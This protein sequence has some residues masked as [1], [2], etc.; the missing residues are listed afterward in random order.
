MS[1]II[2]IERIALNWVE[3]GRVPDGLIRQGIRW[4]CR[5]R[6]TEIAAHE[7]ESAAPELRAFLDD[8]AKGPIAPLPEQANAQH[9]EV[10]AAF[11]D[12]VLGPHRKYSCCYWPPGVKDL[13]AAET[14]ALALTCERAG[15]ADGQDI[16]ELGCGWGS[17][18]LWLGEH[19]P[20]ARIT[21][22]SN[23][24]SQRQHIEAIATQRGL[25][26][27]RV[28]TADMN[29][30]TTESRFH[31]VVSVEMF[32][33]MR[34][35][36]T[37]FQRIH[38]WLRPGGHFFMH[39]FC[40]RDR[41]YPFEDKGDDDW[42]SRYFFSGGI[43]PSD[44]L[45]LRFQYHLSLLDQWRWSG[46]HYERTANAWLA[47]LDERRE[48]ILPILASAYGPDQAALWCQR[49]RLFF[50]AVAETFG[51]DGGRTWW[52]SHYLFERREVAR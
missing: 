4:L 14:A 46:E 1:V 30:F 35:W 29:A 52:V 33:H 47:N 32:E 28:I 20:A 19:Y 25:T 27:I 5:R 38:G 22:V 6:L 21:A 12:Q 49:W 42:M 37:L 2:P 48:A 41:P 26:N 18:T 10:P 17:L 16:L 34:N 51:Y 44:A 36:G 23:S 31:R 7:S 40:H 11:F 50:L 9:Y 24:H 13:A 3:Q 15:V 43:M 39:I 8:M 45:P